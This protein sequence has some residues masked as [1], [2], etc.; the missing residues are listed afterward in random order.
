MAG[1]PLPPPPSF[2]PGGGFHFGRGSGD[3]TP[4]R[5]A[6]TS[7]NGKG[8]VSGNGND[9]SFSSGA[10]RRFTQTSFSSSRASG[11]SSRGGSVSRG[12]TNQPGGGANGVTPGEPNV[13]LE[14]WPKIPNAAGRAAGKSSPNLPRDFGTYTPSPETIR[15]GSWPYNYVS[16][17]SVKPSPIGGSA[18]LTSG[19]VPTARTNFPSGGVSAGTRSSLLSS[20]SNGQPRMNFPSSNA[21][22]DK[23]FASAR[24]TLGKRVSPADTT[25]GAGSSSSSSRADVRVNLRSTMSTTRVNAIETSGG[26]SAT[27]NVRGTSSI[28]VLDASGT[29]GGNIGTESFR[30]SPSLNSRAAPR[31]LKPQGRITGRGGRVAKTTVTVADL[32]VNPLGW[33]PTATVITGTPLLFMAVKQTPRS[34]R[35]ERSSDVGAAPTYADRGGA[36]AAAAAAATAIQ[37]V[38]G[39]ATVAG[40]Y[41][42]EKAR[43][44]VSRKAKE[45]L[46][47][48]KERE[49]ARAKEDAKEA[50]RERR[51]EK[52]RA[53]AAA[54]GGK[55]PLKDSKIS[56]QL[57]IDKTTAKALG[58]KKQK[59]TK[60]LEEKNRTEAAARKA[61]VRFEIA[62]KEK[63]IRV[64]KLRLREREEREKKLLEKKKAADHVAWVNAQKAQAAKETK[65]AKQATKRSTP[66]TPRSAGTTPRQSPRKMPQPSPRGATPVPPHASPLPSPRLLFDQVS[67]AAKELGANIVKSI[68]SSPM[69]TPREN[70]PREV[71]SAVAEKK[72][73]PMTPR[74]DLQKSKSIPN[75]PMKTPPKSPRDVAS[76]IVAS[77]PKSPRMGWDSLLEET[78]VGDVKAPR[79]TGT[80]ATPKELAKAQKLAAKFAAKTAAKI[81]AKK[82]E[83]K[84]AASA[85][86][87]Q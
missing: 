49:A 43:E 35:V 54:G 24:S 5:R 65:E 56:K 16:G 55:S 33:L 59:E 58:D 28:N 62:E 80:V 31:V 20:V 73:P 85:K 7:G 19:R 46:A 70:S 60:E 27:S 86:K 68:P 29:S 30:Q 14:D 3:K 77:L 45:R 71:G 69:K 10:A 1:V 82:A 6:S 9:N 21:G 36:A 84:A 66:S 18:N 75:S 32:G 37:A 47:A 48:R 41:A 11:S 40:L 87:C 23:Y 42:A 57:E 22:G 79:A 17:G 38:A 12:A 74:G 83:K 52:E 15:S 34:V 67:F 78:I 8:G 64:E 76:N 26:T 53:R 50:E 4:P 51:R 13:G 44:D 72:S 25:F 63:Q 61:K 39:A 2:G 81:A